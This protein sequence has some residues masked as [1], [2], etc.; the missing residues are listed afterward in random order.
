VS[1]VHSSDNTKSPD[2]VNTHAPLRFPV[3]AQWKKLPGVLSK[4]E[5]I[6]LP[7]CAFLIILSGIFLLSSTYIKNTEVVAAKGG[8]FTE[9][10]LGSPR[11]INPL[12]SEGNDPD[13]DLVQL[14]FSGLLAM[15][16]DGSIVPDLAKDFEIQEG[17]KLID[18]NLREDVFWHDGEPFTSD[19]VVFTIQTIQDAKYKSPI[20]TNWIGVKVEKV[21]D[22]K[23]RFQ[24]QEP[25]A[26]FLERLTVKILPSHI[27][28]SINAESFPFS[29]YN[30][31]AV[32][33]GPYRITKVLQEKSG[34]ITEIQLGENKRYYESH[35][36][37]SSLNFRFFSNQEDLLSE[38]RREN[39]QGFSLPATTEINSNFQTYSFSL[40][41]YFAVFFNLNPATDIDPIFKKKEMRQALALIIDKPALLQEV[42][43][44]NARDIV[45]PLL[46]DLFG[47]DSISNQGAD[48]LKALSLF[49]KEGYA[50]EN[51]KIVKLPPKATGQFTTDLAKG[52]NGEQVRNLQECLAKDPSIYPEATVNGYFGDATFQAVVR[53]QEKYASE[54]LTPAGITKGTGKVGQATR[55][56]L[57]TVCFPQVPGTPLKITLT[58]L[59][60][61]PLQNV[62][63]ALQRQWQEFGMEVEIRTFAPADLEKDVIKPRNYQL[64]LFG[65]VLGTIPDPYPFWHSSQ[66]KDPGL[67]LSQYEN[68][69]VDKLLE[70]ARKEMDEQE[71]TDDFNE[72]QQLIL[73]DAP[74]LFLYDTDYQYAVSKDIKGIQGGIIGDPSQRFLTISQWSIETKRKW[75]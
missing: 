53:F 1:T 36:Y 18:L 12:Y 2:P 29:L 60:Q 67:N 8:T 7:L 41:R 27:W 61:S 6:L 11:F 64:L 10:I 47:L 31:Q 5:R 51:G 54:I 26:P 4:K 48:Q 73:Q 63:E 65:E 69:D 72:I 55:N 40:P 20:R 23:V 38:A 3:F 45:S 9:G 50:K 49:E 15:R 21:S 56:K 74:A 71:R 44:S 66:K 62:A 32:G 39:L 70:N 24:L 58:T 37:I 25:Y 16:S 42:F 46:P 68:K 59:Q 17:G 28:Q 57:N 33:T 75:K 22:H 43:N 14:I 30:I 19:D 13:R 35:P 34:A 52:S